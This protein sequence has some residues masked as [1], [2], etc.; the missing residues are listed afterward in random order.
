[1]NA[2]R[3]RKTL[4]SDTLHVPELKP[5]IGQT[6]EITVTVQLQPD[7]AVRAEFW[8]GIEGIPDTAEEWAA[9]QAKFRAW[10]ADPRFMAYWPTL[11]H[12]LETDFASSQRWKEAEKAAQRLRES[13]YDFDAWRE[14]R[15]FDRLHA[16]DHLP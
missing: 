16:H 15:E 10:R 4:D 3:I 12:M 14:Q 9:R 13:G 6:A 1:M 11:D 8:G 5:L 7:P 2:I